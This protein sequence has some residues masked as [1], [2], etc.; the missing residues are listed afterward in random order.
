[1]SEQSAPADPVRGYEERLAALLRQC[2]EDFQVRP[3]AFL[4]NCRR[5]L[6]CVAY[7]QLSSQ[8]QNYQPGTREGELS[9][10]AGK[11]PRKLQA[12]WRFVVEKSNLAVHVQGPGAGEPSEDARTCKDHLD[13][14]VRWY[15][16]PDEMRVDTLPPGIAGPLEQLRNGGVPKLDLHRELEAKQQ[17]IEHRLQRQFQQ[18]REVLLRQ[19]RDSQEQGTRASS[20]DALLREERTQRER[21]EQ[22]ILKQN[23]QLRE[24]REQLAER[25]RPLNSTPTPP[26]LVLVSGGS[27]KP[28]GGRSWGRGLVVMGGSLL[29]VLVLF[30][31]ARLREEPTLASTPVPLARSLPPSV[32][33]Q[34]SASVVVTE[35]EFSAPLAPPS[36]RMVASS[37]PSLQCPPG[38]IRIEKTRH[39]V[40]IP[41]RSWAHRP[42]GPTE[43]ID[44]NP[45]CID[46][47]L[48]SISEYNG[49]PS[50]GDCNGQRQGKTTMQPV[51]SRTH[52]E[53]ARFCRDVRKGQLPTV[54][55]REVA[56]RVKALE[57]HNRTGEWS[58]EP[59]PAP[60]FRL[61]PVQETC[62]NKSEQCFMIF[63]PQVERIPD[64]D[65]SSQAL[66]QGWNRDWG[67]A[68]RADVGFRCVFTG[69]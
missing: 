31:L 41:P 59:F 14:I 20:L 54:M 34:V 40:A 42:T 23:N 67:S 43:W 6:E 4:W 57:I 35:Q 45:F 11:L 21:L 58:S 15:F 62:K 29:A 65:T 12:E 24:A 68:R 22:E 63:A 17:E 3:D 48:V 55:Q 27:Q 2:S 32:S 33:T 66:D 52:E 46:T 61:G 19:L 53:A 28:P 13:K 36:A 38:M 25:E 7:A 39:R 9:N 69:S 50:K 47:S 60:I 30:F 26:P 5:C 10:F 49:C 51:L 16:D 64:G 56:H 18:E 1:M 44:V 37:Q 8:Q